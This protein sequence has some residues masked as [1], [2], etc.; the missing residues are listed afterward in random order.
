MS[1]QFI[2]VFFLFISISSY[3]QISWTGV[4][5]I[6]Q[7]YPKRMPAEAR[8]SLWSKLEIF[9]NSLNGNLTWKYSD[10]Q[11]SSFYIMSG[12]V[13]TNGGILELFFERYDTCSY[14]VKRYPDLAKPYVTMKKEDEK[15]LLSWSQKEDP[16]FML[17]TKRKVGIK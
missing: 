17:I 1:K 8:K 5:T 16:K 4:Y 13:K 2:F 11:F 14:K 3:G 10:Q 7:D 15:Y 6:R 9:E 12:V